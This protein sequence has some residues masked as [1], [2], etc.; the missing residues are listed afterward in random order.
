MSSPVSGGLVTASLEN[1]GVTLYLLD[2]R[3]GRFSPVF[4]LSDSWDVHHIL[5]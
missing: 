5:I 1:R 3:R 2:S 4:A